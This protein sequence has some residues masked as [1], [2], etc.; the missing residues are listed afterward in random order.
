[1]KTE[2][3]WFATPLSLATASAL[4]GL[5]VPQIEDIPDTLFATNYIDYTGRKSKASSE[6]IKLLY[7]MHFDCG[8]WLL[9]TIEETFTITEDAVAYIREEEIR[10]CEL[11]PKIV[12]KKNRGVKFNGLY[13]GDTVA[14]LIIG[15]DLLS[16][17]IEKVS[18]R[19]D[20][21]LL[22]ESLSILPTLSEAVISFFDAISVM[23]SDKLQ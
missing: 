20:L 11:E 12:K 2:P 21:S 14:S 18:H 7:K 15:V 17:K 10:I 9:L 19:V 22:D 8:F 6:A 1:M 16:K 23:N 5:E 4:A 13:H 3:N